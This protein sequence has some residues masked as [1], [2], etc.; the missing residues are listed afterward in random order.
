MTLAAVSRLVL[1][2][3]R[4]CLFSPLGREG[5]RGVYLGGAGLPEQSCTVYVLCD[6]MRLVIYTGFTFILSP[7]FVQLLTLRDV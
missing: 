3:C 4:L 6:V 1:L 7:R 2:S 5:R